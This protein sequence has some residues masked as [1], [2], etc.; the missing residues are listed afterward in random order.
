MKILRE[1]WDFLDEKKTSIGAV[2]M[3][4]GHVLAKSPSTA[5]A[6]E[7]LSEIGMVIT[8]GGLIHKGVKAAK[9]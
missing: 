3:L 4:V 6:G 2:F 5:V 1:I 9:P 7:V 8:T